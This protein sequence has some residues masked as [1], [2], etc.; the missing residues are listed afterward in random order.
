MAYT[1]DRLFINYACITC[2]L[3]CASDVNVNFLYV[4]DHITADL[5]QRF[6]PKTSSSHACQCMLSISVMKACIKVTNGDVS[7]KEL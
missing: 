6:T 2:L 5:L 1:N 4:L 3:Y 7:K